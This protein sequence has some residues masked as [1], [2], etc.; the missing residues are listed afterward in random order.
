MRQIQKPR[1]WSKGKF[2]LTFALAAFS[3]GFTTGCSPEYDYL[4]V[5]QLTFPPTPIEVTTK[6]VSMAAGSGVMIELRPVSLSYE[7]YD[8]TVSVAVESENS[9]IARIIRGDYGTEFALV[10]VNPGTTNLRIFIEDEH[11]ENMTV[12]VR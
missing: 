9:K 1:I 4:E 10:G 2:I 3:I 6:R 12:L 5:K 7:E 11:E 8:N